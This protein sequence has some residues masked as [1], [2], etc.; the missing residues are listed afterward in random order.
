MTSRRPLQSVVYLMTEN[1]TYYC[2]YGEKD[3]QD[4]GYVRSEYLTER[5]YTKAEVEELIKAAVDELQK[6]ID[7]IQPGSGNVQVDG[8]N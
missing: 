5:Y 1:D 4:T 7:A 6:K 8:E 2:T 3:I